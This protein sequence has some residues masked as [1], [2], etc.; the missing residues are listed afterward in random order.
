MKTLNCFQQ[1]ASALCNTSQSDQHYCSFVKSLNNVDG[2]FGYR[3][4]CN[5]LNSRLKIRKHL[6]C[7]RTYRIFNLETVA[8]TYGGWL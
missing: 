1:G 3:T 2:V 6:T 4:V 5:G 8:E 7:K